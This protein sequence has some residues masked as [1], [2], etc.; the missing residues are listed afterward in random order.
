MKVACALVAVLG[1]PTLAQAQVDLRAVDATGLRPTLFLE[2]PFEVDVELA[3]SPSGYSGELEV[4]VRISS[5]DVLDPLD[6]VVVTATVSV[7]A[8]T[9]EVRVLGSTPQQLGTFRLIAELDPQNLIPETDELNND[10]VGSPVVIVG[11]DLQVNRLVA[12]GLPQG[13]GGERFPYQVDY[14]NRGPST[15][16]D[17]VVVVRWRPFGEPEV[18][19]AR[20]P[21]E[22]LISLR[23]RRFTGEFVVPE[24]TTIGVAELTASI[25]SPDPIDPEPLNNV[26][27]LAFPVRNPVPNLVGDIISTSTAVEAGASLLINR[28]VENDGLADMTE[29]VELLYVLSEDEDIA[30]SD[31][32]LGRFA[33]P[34]LE[35]DRLAITTDMPP[36]PL[37]LEPGEYRLGMILDPDEDLEEVQE[38]DN[39]VAGPRIS[40]FAPDLQVATSE[41]PIGRRG[42]IYSVALVAVGGPSPAYQWRLAEGAV[43]GLTLESSTGIISGTPLELGRY[44]LVVEVVSGT[45]RAQRTLSLRVADPSTDVAVGELRLPPAIIGQN[46]VTQLVPEGGVPLLEPDLTEYYLWQALEA[47]PSALMLSSTGELSGTVTETSTGVREFRVR[48]EDA[49][50]SSDEGVARVQ[51]VDPSQGVVLIADLLPHAVIDREYCEPEVVQLRAEGAFPPFFFSSAEI[52]PGLS[53]AGTGELCGQPE[54]L[55]EYRFTVNVRD[56]LGVVDQ[57]QFLLRVRQ[58][59]SVRIVTT[60]LPSTAVGSSYE[61]AVEAEGGSTPY[62][63]AVAD[64]ELPPG[65]T[66]QNSGR[67]TGTS[68]R[69]GRYVFA[70]R[71]TDTRGVDGLGALSI[72]VFPPRSS[73]EGGCR[74]VSGGDLSLVVSALGL[75]FGLRLRRARRLRTGEGRPA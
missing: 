28:V 62:R 6:P 67:I 70:V 63:F 19:L 46:Y 75:L 30:V 58:D 25:E 1:L 3:Q 35:V 72:D 45:A 44:E 9:T 29:P 22:S 53:L 17:V 12:L 7:T 40:V 65:L 54:A 21:P 4:R 10:V 47:P 26:Q 66:L 48:V 23:M 33:V 49:T 42:V 43:P 38:A 55:G 69:S 68:T 31:L 52:P 36:I 5:D 57:A 32:S 13:F 24:G 61:A 74:G 34:A 14:S 18:E 39:V 60:E 11:A 41:L 73:D 64:G 51:V 50:G 2:D 27:I 37:A 71:A 56:A 20:T 16:D 8:T 15:A 59:D